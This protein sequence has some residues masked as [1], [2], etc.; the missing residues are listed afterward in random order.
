MVKRK[1]RIGKS[2]LC[3]SCGKELATYNDDKICFTCNV[4]PVDV[5]KA[6]KEIKGLANGKDKKSDKQ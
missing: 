3:K 2:R 1:S 6:L 5:S 4:N